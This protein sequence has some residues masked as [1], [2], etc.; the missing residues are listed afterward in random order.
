MFWDVFGPLLSLETTDRDYRIIDF[1]NGGKWHLH[2][3]DIP[4]QWYPVHP[5]ICYTTMS[6]SS[7]DLLYLVHYMLCLC[8]ATSCYVLQCYAMLCWWHPM[9]QHVTLCHV[10]TLLCWWSQCFCLLQVGLVEDMV[11]EKI[12]S[13]LP[14]HA[15]VAPLDQASWPL[16]TP[17][18]PST[19]LVSWPSTTMVSLSP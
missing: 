15:Y 6:C 10:N 16:L 13:S 5:T 2:R 4:I 12:N 3:Y 9:L 19:S 7:Y 1:R 14:V 8:C 17:H 11:N 18:A